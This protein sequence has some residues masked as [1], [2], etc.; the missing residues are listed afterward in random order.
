VY[1]PIRIVHPPA[2]AEESEKKGFL[3]M[4]QAFRLSY[5]ILYCSKSDFFVQRNKLTKV[6]KNYNVEIAFEVGMINQA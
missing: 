6:T 3:Y 5:P 2:V 1:Q 4:Y